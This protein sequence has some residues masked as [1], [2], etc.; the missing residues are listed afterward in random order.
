MDSILFLFFDRI[1]RI[2]R[3]LFP[4]FPEE[5]LETA[6]ACGDKRIQIQN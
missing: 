4:G 6:I 2:L 1:Y 5:S 3:I